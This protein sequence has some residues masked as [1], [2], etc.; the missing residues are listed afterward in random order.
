MVVQ[1]TQ[2]VHI[3]VYDGS[4]A[5]W[6]EDDPCQPVNAYAASKLEGE[7]YVQARLALS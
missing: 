1:V 3:Q 2:L 4:K 6:K 7:R 5:W